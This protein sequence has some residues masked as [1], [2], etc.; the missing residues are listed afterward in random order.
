MKAI[1]K[2]PGEKPRV[3]EI[4]NELSTL[5]EAVEGSIQAVPLVADA[6]IICNGEGKLIGLPYNIRILN[7]VFVGNILF[8]GVAGEEFCSLTNEQ[9]SLIDERVLKQG[10]KLNENP[11]CK[12]GV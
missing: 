1:I 6:C 8:V 2:K 12:E 4:E 7:E 5:Q 3:I 11:C 10:G 9:I